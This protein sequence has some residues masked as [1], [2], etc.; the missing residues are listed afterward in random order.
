MQDPTGPLTYWKSG[1]VSISV[2]LLLPANHLHIYFVGQTATHAPV[3]TRDL[4][5]LVFNW[6]LIDSAMAVGDNEFP[7]GWEREEADELSVGCQC[8]S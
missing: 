2:M 7:P 6:L 3:A 8:Y 4:V 5:F 1:S